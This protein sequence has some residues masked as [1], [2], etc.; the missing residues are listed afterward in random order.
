M[1]LYRWLQMAQARLGAAGIDNAYLESQ[2]LAAHVL[3][4]DRAWIIAHPE[5]DFTDRG[6]ADVLQRRLA[7]EPLAYILGWREFFGRRFSVG[8]DVLIPR[9]ETEILVEAAF[10][11]AL[12][13]EPKHVLDLGTGSGCIGITLKLEVP[14]WHV[15][16]SDV[17][18]RA[19]QVAQ[20][21][22]LDLKVDLDL[23]N[24]DG[25]DAFATN[26]FDLIVTNPPYVADL[27]DL[28]PEVANFEPR[29]ALFAGPRGTFFYEKLARDAGRIINGD[30][31]LITEIGAGQLEEV[32]PIFAFEGWLLMKVWKDLAEIDRVLAFK[33]Y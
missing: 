28:M 16:A 33:L 26:G 7:R 23:V 22:A 6:G 15:V 19:L 24:C 12:L 3:G 18:E 13:I 11:S 2:L 21:N 10:E 32:Q 5:A 17:S 27:A 4:V 9:Q 14:A 31:M 30:G 8:P 25:A 1:K 29:G 20:A